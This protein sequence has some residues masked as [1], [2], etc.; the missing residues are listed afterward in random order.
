MAVT[1]HIKLTLAYD[2]EK[3]AGWQIQP[4]QR[5]VQQTLKN[6]L[7]KFLDQEIHPIGASR[8]DS[9][10]HALGQVVK[11]SYI[12]NLP[13]KAF[14]PGVNTLL[15]QDVRVLQAESVSEDFHPIFHPSVK[16]YDYYI[17][18]SSVQQPI[19]ERYCYSAAYKFDV[20][21]FQSCLQSL[22]GEH[23]FTSF[24]AINTDVVNK[25]RTLY[26]ATIEPLQLNYPLFQQGPFWRIRFRGNGFLRK[27]VRNI[28]GTVFEISKIKPSKRLRSI[29]EILT[30]KDR[31]QAGPTAPAKGLF[32]TNIDYNK[33][34]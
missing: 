6:A 28:V 2:G 3:F 27:M 9:G 16:T 15:D 19:L 4:S 24:C 31:T 1:Q 17:S 7:T 34:N 13:L 23:D 29:D 20:D 21:K 26:E 33:T 22:V 30:A 12:G 18:T 11:F 8:T 10:V 14:V 25:V 32:L 5:T